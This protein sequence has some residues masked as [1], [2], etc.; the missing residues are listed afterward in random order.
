MGTTRTSAQT[1][2]LDYLCIAWRRA[3]FDLCRCI[4][5]CAIVVLQADDY[6]S[7]RREE[8]LSSLHEIMKQQERDAIVAP[9]ASV[10]ARGQYMPVVALCD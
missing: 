5:W 2:R 9:L 3:C 10:R 8:L 1:W 6:T 4:G 7:Q